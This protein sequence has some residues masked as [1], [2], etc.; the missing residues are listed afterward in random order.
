MPVPPA[1]EEIGRLEAALRSA[2]DGGRK[3]LVPYLTGGLGYG[4]PC[5]PRD[6]R[7]LSFL[8]RALGTSAPLAEATDRANQALPDRVVARLGDVAE[9]GGGVA[10]LGLAYKPGTHV[11]DGSQ[12]L[13]LA[14]ALAAAGARV[15]AY[16]PL[17]AEQARRDLPDVVTVTDTLEEAVE[18]AEVVLVCT[19]DPAFRGAA[20]A[21]LSREGRVVTVLDFW[22]TLEGEL[23]DRPFVRYLPV[24]RCLDAPGSSERIAR[25]WNERTRGAAQPDAP[26]RAAEKVAPSMPQR[27]TSI[28]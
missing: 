9:R 7:A 17:A 25:L 19:P 27:A 22:R 6:N 3:L 24:G 18:G 10:V 13:L 26:R 12:G 8:A 20:A 16:D 1:P 5:F 4:G 11:A 15:R 2:R 14:E 28:Q 23:A 21:A